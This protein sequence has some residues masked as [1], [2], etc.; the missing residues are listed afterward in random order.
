MKESTKVYI[1]LA[2][3]LT[4]FF[5]LLTIALWMGSYDANCNEN[6]RM[7]L[8]ETL[9]LEFAIIKE[10]IHKLIEFFKQLKVF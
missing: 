2:T 8:V 10:G 9:K 6:C 4:L 1:Q 7:T 3:L 5:M